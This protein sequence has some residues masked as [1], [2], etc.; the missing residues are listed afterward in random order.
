MENNLTAYVMVGA[1][2]SGKST[3]AE[4]LSKIENAV[5][6]SG[7]NVRAELYGSAEIQGNWVD[8]W[9]RID[10]LVSESCGMSVILDGTH[11][12]K[13]YREEAIALL[14][15]YG[16]EKVEAVVMDASLAT[17]L[18]RNFQRA[19]RNVPDYIVKEMHEKLQRSLKKILDE[20]FDR[21]NY[22]Y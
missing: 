2:G 18:A 12:R 20:D 7:D 15:S 1:P 14:R 6:V 19:E 17:C 9:D 3:Y 10:E 16:Y 11:Y 8:I 4:K 21:V 13:D 22:V 5:I